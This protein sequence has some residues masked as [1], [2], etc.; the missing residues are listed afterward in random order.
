M[1]RGGPGLRLMFGSRSIQ[2]VRVFGIRIGVDPSWFLVL[3]LVI[4]S[5][6]GYYQDAIAGENADSGAFALA[7]ASALLFFGS[8]VLH[9]LGH[10]VVAMRNGIGIEGID[11]FLFGGVAKMSG[12]GPQSPGTELKVAVA[13]P[14]VTVVLAVA[15]A[16][17]GSIGYGWG[18]FWDAAANPSAPVLALFVYMAFINLL[19]LAF[20]LI[21]ALPLDGGRI[22]RAL[23]WWR[24]GDRARA[25]AVAA[26]LGQ[27][28]SYLLIGGG[29]FVLVSWGDIVGGAWLVFLGL[30]LGQIA[31]SEAAYETAIRS[32]IGGVRVADVMDAEPVV[33]PGDLT[34]R[35]A[36]D[37][38]FLR[39][40]WP[41]FP[42]VDRHGHFIGLVDRERAERIPDER[43]DVFTVREIM[44][45][46]EGED[47]RVREDDPL[48]ALLASEPLRRIGALIAVDADGRL[49]GV[50]TL[51]DVRR[52]LQHGG[53]GTAA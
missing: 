11:L 44:R 14:A 42:V 4:Y 21:P 25:T 37:E 36:L 49:S 40:R 16:A 5:L 43:Q 7:V 52:A 27:L 26:R 17:I 51:D 13:G 50:V 8:I 30:F 3:F 48:E 33:V 15:F 46:E 22:V 31:R 19:L 18:E 47:W 29:I 38:Y 45:A 24:T 41:W 9:E 6:T 35:R 12:G 32:R 53:A 23:V 2:L 1:R 28:F 34:I 20:N 39:Y 10:A